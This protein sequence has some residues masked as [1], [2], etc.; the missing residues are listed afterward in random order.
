MSEIILGGASIT[1]ADLESWSLAGLALNDGTNFT[2]E[3]LDFLPARKRT[4]WAQ[5]SDADGS[6][7]VGETHYEN[8]EWLGRIRIEP[9]ATMAL[10]LTKR[11]QLTDKLQQCRG[12]AFV[13]TPANASTS[14]TFYCLEAEY[15][16]VPYTLQG[17]D[18][19]YFGLAPVMRVKITLRP[20]GY[21][22]PYNVTETTYAA[23]LGHLAIPAVPGDVPAEAVLT[24]TDNATQARK[25]IE[26]GLEHTNYVTA[27]PFDLLLDEG[28]L[29]VTGTQ[30]TA[31]ADA[32]ANGGN[33]FSLVLLF[34]DWRDLAKVDDM[35]H[36]G[37]FRVKGRFK[38]TCDEETVSVR[39]LWR[40]GNTP[41]QDNPPVIVPAFGTT[42]YA[43][44]DLGT[45]SVKAGAANLDIYVQAKADAVTGAAEGVRLDLLE[46][47]PTERYGAGAGDTVTIR[48]STLSAY[49]SFDHDPGLALSGTNPEVGTG[50][51]AGAGDVE[52]FVIRSAVAV[53]TGVAA[54]LDLNTG[55]YVGV[56]SVLTNTRLV[57]L[58]SVSNYASSGPR[59]LRAGLLAR[60]TDAN[61]WV[62]IFVRNKKTTSGGRLNRIV[63]Y[64]RV[65]GTRTTIAEVEVADSTLTSGG[66]YT[67]GTLSATVTSGGLIEVFTSPSFFEDATDRVISVTDGSLPA[68]GKAGIY[69][70]RDFTQADPESYFA[71][72]T[73]YSDTLGS[74]QTYAIPSTGRLEIGSEN[75]TYTAATAGDPAPFITRG[76]RLYLPPGDNRLTVKARRNDVGEVDLGL[77]DSTKLKATVQPRYLLPR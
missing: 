61:N 59:E 77:T 18:A 50:A 70:A 69:D 49:D 20:F 75:T 17:D 60:Y 23:P 51:W 63:V 37:S 45:I 74:T 62:G 56:G 15:E 48:G 25:H 13:C 29:S 7:P 36:R 39:L 11:G 72:L 10:A 14:Y 6:T 73:V 65:A 46:L 24:V 54:D 44:V 16:E 57:A 38:N 41:Y 8:A 28:D 52:D 27:S 42:A 31:V 47:I 40:V 58:I 35:P 26:W 68:S 66:G 71:S 12:K 22:A 4:Q 1:G 33:A 43:E 3:A 64:K 19:G 2:L 76:S 5:S 34:P 55:R 32:D 21:G 53:R 30:A 9:Q 67:A